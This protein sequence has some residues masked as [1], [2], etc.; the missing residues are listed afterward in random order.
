MKSQKKFYDFDK[1]CLSVKP[2]ISKNLL[3]ARYD[4]IS[5]VKKNGK[6]MYWHAIHKTD[7]YYEELYK[8]YGKSPKEP[9]Y[10]IDT[11]LMNLSYSEKI[12]KW[13]EMIG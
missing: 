12:Q 1:G 11:S 13:K 2:T 5:R 8:N 3:H 9:E 4:D 10:Q 7:T 6:D